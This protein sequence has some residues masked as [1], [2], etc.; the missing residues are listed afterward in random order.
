VSS[1]ASNTRKLRGPAWSARHLR[2][3]PEPAPASGFHA[4]TAIDRNDRD[5]A[6][7]EA[8]RGAQQGDREAFRFLYLRYKNNVYGYILSI[9]RDPYEAE[10]ATQH[11]FLKLMSVIGK[12]EPQRVPFSAWIIRVARNVAVD[13]QRQHRAIPVEE[14]L[15][16]TRPLEQLGL[17]RRRGLESA[18]ESLPEDQ[19]DVLVLRHL[20]GLTPGEIAS[21]L[22][23]SEASIHGLHHRGR[24]AVKREL[25]ALE[26]APTTR[27]IARAA[28]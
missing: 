7:A 1:S 21:R 19:R 14:V 26:C 11:L 6:I 3:S 15:E 2:S 18:L 5:P 10:D 13:Y 27:G 17:E 8:V 20:V 9:L 28:A 16:A 24:Q 22:G 4:S 25:A 23:R 12:Y